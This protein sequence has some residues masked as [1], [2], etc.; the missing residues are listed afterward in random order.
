VLGKQDLDGHSIC[1]NT[2]Y[3]V[4]QSLAKAL[5]HVDLPDPQ[6]ECACNWLNPGNRLDISLPLLEIDH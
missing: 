4:R 3:V 1:G 6:G 5:V 2:F